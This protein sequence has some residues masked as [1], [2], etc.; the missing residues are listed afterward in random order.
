M[1]RQQLEHKRAGIEAQMRW[2]AFHGADQAL[3]VL[4][5]VESERLALVMDQYHRTALD[6][7]LSDQPQSDQ[8]HRSSD[9]WHRQSDTASN[10]SRAPA[11]R[12]RP[13]G[14]DLVCVDRLSRRSAPRAEDI[15]PRSPSEQRGSIVGDQ[16]MSRP[17][18]RRHLQR[19]GHGGRRRVKNWLSANA[20]GALGEHCGVHRPGLLVRRC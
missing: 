15:G 17:A 7:T 3:L 19:S 9:L 16:C 20:D 18:A 12:A 10:A 4:L 14:D 2:A 5:C 6:R 13:A 8:P 11:C 1:T